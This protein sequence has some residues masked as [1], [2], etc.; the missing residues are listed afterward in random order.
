[1]VKMT[2]CLL[3]F[4]FSVFHCQVY[5]DNLKPIGHPDEY[6]DIS[7]YDE[8]DLEDVTND[9]NKVVDKQCNGYWLVA[10]TPIVPYEPIIDSPLKIYNT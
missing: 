2:P 8:Y 3:I 7:Q 4:C 9:D 1:M 6:L 10:D 5:D